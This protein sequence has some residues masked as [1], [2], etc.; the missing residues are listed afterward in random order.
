MTI[1]TIHILRSSDKCT[2]HPTAFLRLSDVLTGLTPHV[3]SI[4]ILYMPPIYA[5]ISFFSYRF[6]RSFTYYSLVEI[7]ALPP[8]FCRTRPNPLHSVRGMS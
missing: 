7:G 2:F 5:I 6:F 1:V 3:R 8:F 4:R